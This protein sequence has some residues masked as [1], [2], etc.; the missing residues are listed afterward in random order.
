MSIEYT[1]DG[2]WTEFRYAE[3]ENK[4]RMVVYDKLR[5]GYHTPFFSADGQAAIEGCDYD[6]ENHAYEFATYMVSQMVAGNP[7]YALKSRRTDPDDVSHDEVHA[8]QYA[9]NQWVQDADFRTTMDALA[10]DPLFAFGAALVTPKKN[11][12]TYQQSHTPEEWPDVTRISPRNFFRD[13]A[14]LR[15]E[16]V[17][18]LGHR[19]VMD[20]VDLSK[21][22]EDA[23]EDEGWNVD[24][25]EG[26]A[27][28]SLSEDYRPK[29]NGNAP[30]RSEVEIIELWFPGQQLAD[31][32]EDDGFYGTIYTLAVV[33]GAEGYEDKSD[34]IREPRPY[35]GHRSGPYAHCQMMRV[36]DSPWGLAPLVATEGQA[37]DLNDLVRAQNDHIRSYKKLVFVD[38]DS[39]TLASQVENN[40]DRVVVPLRGLGQ[41]RMAD[42]VQQLEIGGPSPAVQAAVELAEERLRRNSGLGEAQTGNAPGAGTT[43]TAAA[44]ASQDATLRVELMKER[45]RRFLEDIG[46]KV[47]FYIGTSSEVEIILDTKAVRE[48]GPVTGEQLDKAL[49]TTFPDQGGQ[50]TEEQVAAIQE[51]SVRGSRPYQGGKLTPG[52]FNNMQAVLDVISVERTSEERVQARLMQA[53]GLVQNSIPAIMQL[54]S[55]ELW[56][57]L[58][59]M[60]GNAVNVPGLGDLGKTAVEAAL[61]VLNGDLASLS[62]MAPPA[63][64]PGVNVGS[65]GAARQSQ[66]QAAPPMRAQ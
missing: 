7:E 27:G 15:F 58:F 20:E 59:E 1:P 14:A 10:L 8:L 18:Y 62:T 30:N 3:A 63:P 60:A 36:P 47:A 38:D 44:I 35:Y 24:A 9:V 17:R 41:R 52:D 56:T 51:D 21:M 13:P 16:E 29:S 64:T 2:L 40:P 32:T 5:R 61:A 43:A 22:V 53:I 50:F 57:D 25:V 19:W 39:G 55:T 33:R 26:I 28:L 46:L 11:R 65:N 45:W 6:P 42:L 54:P 12:S 37:R 31:Y 49:E 34:F 48:L 66:Q 23:P 4:R